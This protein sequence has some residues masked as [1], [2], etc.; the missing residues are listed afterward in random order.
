[1]ESKTT[2]M[3][4]MRSSVEEEIIIQIIQRI[5]DKTTDQLQALF[6]INKNYLEYEDKYITL[7]V[8]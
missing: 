3:L 6:D 4:T 7:Y 2:I 1:M 5:E 8:G